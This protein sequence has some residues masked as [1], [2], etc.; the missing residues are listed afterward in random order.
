MGLEVEP[1][2]K[3]E[4]LILKLITLYERLSISNDEK[5]E[6]FDRVMAEYLNGS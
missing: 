2:T 3:P 1:L 6:T 4:H 5:A